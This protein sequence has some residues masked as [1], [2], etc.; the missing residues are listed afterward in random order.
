M[1]YTS[2]NWKARTVMVQ[3]AFSTIGSIQERKIGLIGLGSIGTVYFTR[4]AAWL[5]S[6][7][8]SIPER[9][10]IDGLVRREVFERAIAPIQ[11]TS[12]RNI[13]R[14]HLEQSD[15]S[16]SIN[17]DGIPVT[18]QEHPLDPTTNTD[19]C[20]ILCYDEILKEINSKV[21]SGMKY[22]VLVICVKAYD[23]ASVGQRLQACDH[24]LHKNATIIWVYNGFTDTQLMRQGTKRHSCTN[25]RAIVSFG[26][27]LK[28]F[29]HVEACGMVR[30]TFF[31]SIEDTPLAATPTEEDDTIKIILSM[32]N[33]AGLPSQL[34]SHQ[35]FK[36]IVWHKAIINAGIN[37]ICSILNRSNNC[38]MENKWSQKCL[39]LIVKE[40]LLVAHS[41]NALESIDRKSMIRDINQVTY[42]T[43]TN[44]CSMLADL[45]KRQ[46]TE[47]ELM[48]GSVV[49]KAQIYNIPTP[50]NQFVLN[51]IQTLEADS[52]NRIEKV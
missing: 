12:H 48:N 1:I 15:S 28:A 34:E 13:V 9:W 52:V 11:K 40:C 35:K 39:G 23:I 26:A 30:T 31:G 17:I 37:P 20:R 32:L 7:S 50:V 2:I 21:D 36:D 10:S 22:D 14:F 24:L 5:R 8:A 51:L 25:Y 49:A 4:I 18:L 3:R 45:R 44:V 29:G 46:R 6:N 19:I 47:I 41:E 38:L 42:N 16:E 33:A 43:K 27:Q